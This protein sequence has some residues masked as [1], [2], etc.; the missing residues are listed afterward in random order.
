M[1]SGTSLVELSHRDRFQGVVRVVSDVPV[2]ISATQVTENLNGKPVEVELPVISPTRTDV[3][4]F[5]DGDGIATEIVLINPTERA[6]AGTLQ[7]FSGAG[8]R[9]KMIIR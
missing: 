2:V 1:S 9:Q 5:Q 4:P 8:E 7:F 6:A 3:V